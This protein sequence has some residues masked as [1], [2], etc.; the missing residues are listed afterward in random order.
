MPSAPPDLSIAPEAP[1]AFAVGCLA[2]LRFVI[3]G[4][5]VIAPAVI[6]L[7]TRSWW[8]LAA[9]LVPLAA[10]VAWFPRRR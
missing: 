3:L 1:R 2:I 6:L 5:G 10:M 8:P 9:A 7:D 4:C